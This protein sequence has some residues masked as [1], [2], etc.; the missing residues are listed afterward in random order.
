MHAAIPTARAASDTTMVT[1]SSTV[2]V[3]AI[4]YLVHG[5]VAGEAPAELDRWS[6]VGGADLCSFA[7]ELT[8]YPDW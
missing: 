1:L 5:R 4:P 2:V 7:S 8:E 3:V 6:P